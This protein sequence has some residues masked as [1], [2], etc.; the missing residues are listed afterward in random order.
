MLRSPLEVEHIL[1]KKV[2]FS[3]RKSLKNVSKAR[4]IGSPAF[5][6]TKKVSESPVLLVETIPGCTVVMTS[7]AK[8]MTWCFHSFNI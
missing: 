7:W 3:E 6:F 2:I 8:L 5:L 1:W 4:K